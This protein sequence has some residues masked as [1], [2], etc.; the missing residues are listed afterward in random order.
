MSRLGG[1]WLSNIQGETVPGPSELRDEE[2]I[3]YWWPYGELRYRA[4]QDGHC[5]RC[6]N[7]ESQGHRGGCEN[8]P[9]A[10]GAPPLRKFTAE[11]VITKVTDCTAFG[12][13]QEQPEARVGCWWYRDEWTKG[14]VN[15]ETAATWNRKGI[16]NGYLASKFAKGD[17]V[18]VVRSGDSVLCSPRTVVSA[19]YNS[20][21]QYEYT[22][23]GSMRTRWDS[24]D[25][26]VL[27][28]PAQREQ[29]EVRAGCWWYRDGWTQ[30]YVDKKIAEAWNREGGR[31][32]YEVSKF[33]KGDR[34]RVIRGDRPE[35]RCVSHA[36]YKD[37]Q[38]LYRRKTMAAGISWWR[39][40]ELDLVEPAS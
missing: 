6:G 3:F 9:A 14:S 21:W 24:E 15:E 5:S 30:C 12:Q 23:E 33:A 1:K 39:E 36:K 16:R 32:G 2:N 19:V 25:M 28:E 26:L 11:G 22:W 10:T 37:G 34:V 29:P 40:D 35:G 17:K 31:A 18:Y 20:G 38:W 7:H 13:K 4:E 27:V 8:A